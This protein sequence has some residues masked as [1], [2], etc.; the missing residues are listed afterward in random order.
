MS[1]R[2]WRDDGIQ[3]SYIHTTHDTDVVLGEVGALQ[4]PLVTVPYLVE[5]RV[6]IVL[7]GGLDENDGSWMMR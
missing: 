7:E 3:M 5:T 4:N 1:S 6:V 2:N